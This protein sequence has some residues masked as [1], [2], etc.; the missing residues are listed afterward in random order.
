MLTI[1]DLSP[2]TGV[3]I[4]TIRYYEQMGVLNPPSAQRAISGATVGVSRS[5]SPSSA[6]PENLGSRLKRSGN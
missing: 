6:M 2:S 3:K 5:V 4:P 1:G